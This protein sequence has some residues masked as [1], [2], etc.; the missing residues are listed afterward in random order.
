MNTPST[1]NELLASAAY[2]GPGFGEYLEHRRDSLGVSQRQLC[3]AIGMQRKTYQRILEGEAKKVDLLTILA[4]AQFLDIGTK[5]LVEIF[6]AGS[7][8]KEVAKISRAGRAGFILKNFDLESLRRKRFIRTITDLDHI[9]DRIKQFFNLDSIYQY[10]SPISGTL[11][12]RSAT[13]VADKSLFF[14]LR[15]V[16]YQFSKLDNPNEY[17]RE[18]LKRILPKLRALTADEINGFRRAQREL[19]RAGITVLFE[20]YLGDTRVYGGTFFIRGSPCVVVTDFYKNYPTIWHSLVHELYHVL[21]DE[22]LIRDEGYH[23]SSD[24]PLTLFTSQISEDLADAFA[25]QLLL[26][27]EMLRHVR[28]YIAM[29]AMVMSR[30]REW[31]VHSKIIYGRYLKAYG[32]DSD[33]KKYGTRIKLDPNTVKQL[34]I[35]PWEM[36]SLDDSVEVARKILAT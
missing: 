12:K 18:Y 5:D 31:G 8:P 16:Q 28:D 9:E 14:W 19:Y 10:G 36:D 3:T 13:P 17:D 20:S 32:G 23:L 27:D 4:V 22:A 24:E 26:S 34:L 30:A 11:F 35:E 15:A 7:S 21:K 29:P 25:A 1:L 33:W 2:D 6:L